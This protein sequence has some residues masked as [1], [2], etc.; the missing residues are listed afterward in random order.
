[1]LQSNGELRHRQK[2]HGRGVLGSRSGKGRQGTQTCTPSQDT[3]AVW[4]SCPHPS[5]QLPSEAR[6][7]M[8]QLTTLSDTSRP[9]GKPVAGGVVAPVPRNRPNS[10]GRSPISK[11]EKRPQRTARLNTTPA[12]LRLAVTHPV[13]RRVC[14]G[15]HPP[16]RVEGTAAEA[17]TPVQ[18]LADPVASSQVPGVPA[19]PIVKTMCIV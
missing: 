10:T 17:R 2:Q 5:R 6:L 12:F 11:T 13:H 7:V 8:P 9:P 18:T 15:P 3:L 14:R 4:M 1:M 19:Q 16:H